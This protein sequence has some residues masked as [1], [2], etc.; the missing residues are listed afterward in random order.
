MKA[1]DIRTVEDLITFLG[2]EKADRLFQEYLIEVI[3]SQNQ[4]KEALFES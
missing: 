4:D 3:G 1:E 2:K